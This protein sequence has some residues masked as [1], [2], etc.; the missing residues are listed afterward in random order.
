MASGAMAFM[1][2]VGRSTGIDLGLESKKR[3]QAAVG[4]TSNVAT[5]PSLEPEQETMADQT[6]IKKN[7]KINTAVALKSYYKA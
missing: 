2:K 1:D 6:K 5:P 7:D 4:N 3:E